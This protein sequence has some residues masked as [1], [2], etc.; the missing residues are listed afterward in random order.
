MEQRTE[1]QKL[2]KVMR[3]RVL[4]HGW[5]CD[6]WG[7]VVMRPDGAQTILLTDHGTEFEA[8]PGDLQDLLRQYQQ[9]ITDT[10]SAM[11]MVGWPIESGG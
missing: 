5:E 2:T 6:L 4:R 11:T 9:V 7:W 10:Q 3:F 8:M 1:I